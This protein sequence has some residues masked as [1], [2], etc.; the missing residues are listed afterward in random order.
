VTHEVEQE[1]EIV[2]N[3]VVEVIG[4]RIDNVQATKLVEMEEYEDCELVE[5][6]GPRMVSNTREVGHIDTHLTRQL[7]DKIYPEGSTELD[8]VEDDPTPDLKMP[9]TSPVILSSRI[10]DYDASDFGSGRAISFESLDEETKSVAVEGS[11]SAE[12]ASPLVITQLNGK[13]EYFTIANTSDGDVATD[14]WRVHDQQ[15]HEGKAKR[16]IFHFGDRAP[17][18]IL[19]PNDKVSIYCGNGSSKAREYDGMTKIHWFNHNVWDDEGDTVYLLRPDGS[20]AHTLTAGSEKAPRSVTK[21]GRKRRRSR[22]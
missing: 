18:L 7:G 3:Q 13:E 14:G 11:G 1:V 8:G 2:S 19:E 21:S 6:P 20:T 10:T 15:V 22:K 12:G 9:V 16:N 5:N 17:G 4:Y